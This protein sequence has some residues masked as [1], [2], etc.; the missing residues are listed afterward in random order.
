MLYG[1]TSH[2]IVG[3]IALVCQPD[4]FKLMIFCMIL[5]CHPAKLLCCIYS[6]T[7]GY[8]EMQVRTLCHLML[9]LCCYQSQRPGNAAKHL[10][11]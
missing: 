4:L 8:S 6:I 2:H 9:Q 3:P 1:Q 10:V 5:Q 7:A 11:Y